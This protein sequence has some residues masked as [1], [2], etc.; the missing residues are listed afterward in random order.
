MPRIKGWKKIFL[1]D[2][3]I[4][5]YINDQGYSITRIAVLPDIKW[6]GKRKTWIVQ[7]HKKMVG[8]PFI[9]KDV[10]KGFGTKQQAL[11]FAINYMKK[12]PRG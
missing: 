6:K 5:A 8:K 12:H 3:S 2:K 9:F 4:T 11:K 7:K 1:I 10:G